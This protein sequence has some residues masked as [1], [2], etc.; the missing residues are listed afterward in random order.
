MRE[1]RGFLRAVVFRVFRAVVLVCPERPRSVH[2]FFSVGVLGIV[3]RVA[4][5]EDVLCVAAQ[6]SSLDIVLNSSEH[7]ATYMYDEK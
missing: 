6:R 2:V 5:G 4:G 1:P 7:P 3:A